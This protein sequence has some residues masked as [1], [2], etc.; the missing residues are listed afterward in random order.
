MIVQN[1]T[2]LYLI[3]DGVVEDETGPPKLAKLKLKK[4][5]HDKESEEVLKVSLGFV[6]RGV[7]LPQGTKEQTLRLGSFPS[8]D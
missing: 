7:D 2:C 8:C 6:L 1:L 3:L 5:Y 4:F